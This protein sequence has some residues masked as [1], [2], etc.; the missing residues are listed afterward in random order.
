VLQLLAALDKALVDQGHSHAAGSGVGAAV[1]T[2]T[3][4]EVPAGASR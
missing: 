1:R 4:A 2:Y 3:R